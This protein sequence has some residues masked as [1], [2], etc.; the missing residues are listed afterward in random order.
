MRHGGTNE[1]ASRWEFA[2]A[3]AAPVAARAR[4]LGALALAAALAGCVDPGRD[5]DRRGD[6]GGG[7]VLGGILG[8]VLGGGDGRGGS[9]GGGLLGQSV[10]YR[11][12]DDR[13]FTASFQPFGGGVSV[14]TGR[15]THRLH[16]RDGDGGRH[17]REYRS[18]DGDV[19][20]EV[21]GDRAELSVEDGDDYEGCERR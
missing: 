1:P 19:R 13:R 9:G 7:D 11:C 4:I 10:S 16:T 6:D 3:P 8:G 17:R 18:E 2:G 21:D 15:R 20:L 12:D 14:D 5:R